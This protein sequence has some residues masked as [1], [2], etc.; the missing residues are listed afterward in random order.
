MVVEIATFIRDVLSFIK[1]D[2]TTNIIDP[3]S[4]KRH[5]SS[6]FIMTSYPQRKVQYPLITLKV[7]NQRE[8]RESMQTT[9]M[10]VII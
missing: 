9:S 1:S 6:K 7:I 2:L 4:S 5:S 10:D 3:I 8:A